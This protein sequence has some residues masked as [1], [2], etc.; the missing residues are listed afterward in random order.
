MKLIVPLVSSTAQATSC[1]R[2]DAGQAHLGLDLRTGRPAA[3]GIVD[4]QFTVADDEARR[5]PS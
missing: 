3:A 2:A 4:Q 5:A 1:N